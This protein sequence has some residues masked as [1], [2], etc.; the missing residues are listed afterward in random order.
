MDSE[1]AKSTNGKRAEAIPEVDQLCNNRDETPGEISE[2][3]KLASVDG[4][5]F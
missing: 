2:A 4:T 1:K 3:C 5:Y